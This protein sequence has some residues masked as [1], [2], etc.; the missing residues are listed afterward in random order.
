[1]I[2]PMK[3][4]ML[5]V[6]EHPVENHQIMIDGPGKIERLLAVVSEQRG[7]ALSLETTP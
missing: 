3:D 2:A 6:R 4:W 7:I 5:S 1:M